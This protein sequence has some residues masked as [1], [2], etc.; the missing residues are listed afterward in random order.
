[1]L[2][3]KHNHDKVREPRLGR[4]WCKACDKCEV[5]DGN[6]CPVCRVRDKSKRR[7]RK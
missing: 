6:K 2:L 5:G 1:M 3:K 7:K 4:K